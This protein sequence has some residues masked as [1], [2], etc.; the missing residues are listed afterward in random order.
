MRFASALPGAVLVVL[1]FLAAVPLARAQNGGNS[2]NVTG[3]VTDPS[4]AV[5]PGATVT[6]HNPVSQFEQFTTT[7][8]TGNFAFANV[9]FNPYHMTVSATGFAGHAQDIDVRSS[10]P[11]SVK[12]SL[13]LAGANS[14]VT[15]EAAGDLLETDSTSHTDID[16]ALFNE[17]PLES[18]SSSVSALVTQTSPGVAADSNGLF[19]GLGDHAENSFSVDGQPITDQQ[20]KVFSNQIPV[21]SIQSL[22]VIDG[23]P[24]AEYGD[25]T[26]LVIDV[27]TRS[28]QGVTTPHGSITTSYGT[29]GSSNLSG[30]LAY[31]GLKWGNFISLSG[32]NT[33]RFLDPPEFT[34]IHDKGNEENAFDRADYQFTAADSLHLNLGFSR[35]WFQTP[36]SFDAQDATPWSGVV[37][38]NGGLGP[39]GLAVGPTDQRSQILTYNVAPSWTHLKG[40]NTVFTLGAFVR[41]DQYNYYPSDNPFAD[42]GPPSLQRETVSQLRFLT[43][44]GAR[45]RVSYVKGINNIKAGITYEQTVLR[46]HDRLGIVDPT[47]NAPCLTANTDPTQYNIS[48]AFIPVQGFTDPSQ[49]AAAGDQ[50]IIASSPNAPNTAQFPVFNPILLPFDLTRGGSLFTTQEFFPLHTG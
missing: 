36:N 16:R 13:E 7:D 14:T 4:G 44:A 23:A 39:N 21:D 27:T 19:H 37:V 48:S 25:K 49:C 46:E 11:L 17:V 31:G 18:A 22:E 9:P 41:H 28:G 35:S 6:I 12:I 47:L 33:G 10:V 3:T 8:A 24:P 29:F 40:S 1:C 30:D 43:N 50:E 26:S 34:V 5:I 38:N 32:L 15:V 45:A 20:S 42:L 2:T